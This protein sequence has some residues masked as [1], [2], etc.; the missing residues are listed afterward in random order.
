MLQGFMVSA[1]NATVVQQQPAKV[2]QHS[3]LMLKSNV[4]K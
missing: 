2:Q 1:K 4:V 3:E